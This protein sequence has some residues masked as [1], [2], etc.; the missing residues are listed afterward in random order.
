MELIY[1]RSTEAPLPLELELLPHPFPLPIALTLT[2]PLPPLQN[3]P[4]LTLTRPQP[5]GKI[6]F[7][8]IPLL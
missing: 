8:Y 1:L 7:V 4:P 5:F 2:L 3:T 6:L